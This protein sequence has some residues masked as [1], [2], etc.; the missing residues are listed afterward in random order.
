MTYRDA[1]S[2]DDPVDLALYPELAYLWAGS[3][4]RP[5]VQ[6]A[7]YAVRP[8]Y[9]SLYPAPYI[10]KWFEEQEHEQEQLAIAA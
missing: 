4:D 9:P 2:G 8:A 7:D 1:Y 6:H 10:P 3:A 5:T